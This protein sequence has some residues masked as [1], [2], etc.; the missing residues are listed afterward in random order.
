MKG[1]S[2]ELFKNT[3]VYD[4][5]K[6]VKNQDSIKIFTLISGGKDINLREPKFGQTLLILAVKNELKKSVKYLLENKADLSIYDSY[7]GT[8]AIIEASKMGKDYNRDPEILKMLLDNGANPNDIEKGKRRS[9]NLTRSTPLIEASKCCLEKVELLVQGGA[10]IN[11]I[12]EYNQ[13][14]LYSALNGSKGKELIVKYLLLNG[15]DYKRPLKTTKDGIEIKIENKLR[16]WRFDL[17]SDKYKVKMEIVD[18]LKSK[19]VD[20]RNTKI[21][22]KYLDK[23]PEEYLSKY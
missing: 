22:K 6:A 3:E 16:D 18:F 20:Y 12:N 19:G 4:L 10:D 7:D 13:S 5:A 14:A 23:Y 21:P 17:N 2:F 9:D 15:A 8:S 1:N 11:F